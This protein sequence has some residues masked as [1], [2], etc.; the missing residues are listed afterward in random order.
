MASKLQNI[1][2]NVHR[3]IY[4]LEL[5]P[6]RFHEPYAKTYINT[7]LKKKRLK[8]L[9]V[10]INLKY[11]ESFFQEILKYSLRCRFAQGLKGYSRDPRFD[12]SK[13]LYSETRKISRRDMGFERHSPRSGIRQNLGMGYGLGPRNSLR[14]SSPG[15]LGGGKEG[16][17]KRKGSLQLRLWN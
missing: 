5:T 10:L 4:T 11:T 3:Q 6:G 15:R 17:G 14:A 8:W 16:G 1:P 12:R 7:N 2:F 9:L 13:A